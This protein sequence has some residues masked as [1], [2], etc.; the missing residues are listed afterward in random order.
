MKR[1]CHDRKLCRLTE[2]QFLSAN[3]GM[4]TFLNLTRSGRAIMLMIM[5]NATQKIRKVKVW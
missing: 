3:V 5:I 1:L 4:Q 2:N